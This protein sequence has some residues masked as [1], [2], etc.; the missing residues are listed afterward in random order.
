[1]YAMYMHIYLC[2]FTHIGILYLY[3]HTYMYTI[4]IYIYSVL[5]SK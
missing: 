5:E 1:M 3:V 4:Y 2:I